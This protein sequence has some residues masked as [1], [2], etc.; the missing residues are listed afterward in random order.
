MQ[1]IIENLRQV[2]GTPDFI[3]ADGAVDYAAM[4]EYLVGGMILCIVISSVFKFISK[5]V[6]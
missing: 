2:L 5:A 3:L 6:F 1:T 4:L